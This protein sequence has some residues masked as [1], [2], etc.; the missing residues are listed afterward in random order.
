MAS[1]SSE[2]LLHE[3]LQQTNKAGVG[4]GERVLAAAGADEAGG[5]RRG[6]TG[7]ASQVASQVRDHRVL[8]INKFA[9]CRSMTI[10]FL[11]PTGRI[12]YQFSGELALEQ[13]FVA[14]RVGGHL[15]EVHGLCE[16]H[17]QRSLQDDLRDAPE[18]PN[19][20]YRTTPKP[21]F[22]AKSSDDTSSSS[23]V[24]SSR[25]D[26]SN[27]LCLEIFLVHPSETNK[28]YNIEKLERCV[29]MQN[30]SR[31][32]FATFLMQRLA[33]ESSVPN[34]S[35]CCSG[36]GDVKEASRSGTNSEMSKL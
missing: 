15:E 20:C 22:V 9:H 29:G 5:G 17:R 16:S 7:N 13:L 32:T 27:S 19:Q 1:S 18:T 8:K 21:V 10:E 30:M 33:A 12:L 3:A 4:G 26:W 36:V 31:S 23:S 2:H 11:V 35:C 34:D 25:Q 28:R 24:T 6:R 14:G